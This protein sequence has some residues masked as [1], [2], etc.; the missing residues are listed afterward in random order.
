MQHLMRRWHLCSLQYKI[1]CFRRTQRFIACWIEFLLFHK[2]LQGSESSHYLGTRLL[3][4]SIYHFTV[5][6]LIMIETTL[7]GC[8]SRAQNNHVSTMICAM[9]CLMLT[10][11]NKT[12][13]IHDQTDHVS[14][15]CEHSFSKFFA[16]CSSNVKCH[17]NFETISLWCVWK[18]FTSILQFF[19][20]F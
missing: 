6:G 12:C 7:R 8:F 15:L 20:L 17:T 5:F 9:H 2:D 19:F 16:V 10:L 11:Y 13:F 1:F 4:V 18:P 3:S 14:T